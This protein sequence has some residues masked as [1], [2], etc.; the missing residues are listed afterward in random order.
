MIQELQ[1]KEREKA[2]LKSKVE[3]YSRHKEL[4]E[5]R[6]NVLI[7]LTADIEKNIATIDD[8][9]SAKSLREALELNLF[10]IEISELE[11]SFET[12]SN[13]YNTYLRD[14][15]SLVKHDEFITSECIKNYDTYVEILKSLKLRSLRSK[16]APNY[17]KSFDELIYE[18]DWEESTSRTNQEHKNIVFRR[19]VEI[20]EY[21]DKMK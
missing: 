10:Q 1:R 9:A 8:K 15:E 19:I 20:V 4:L 18:V 13:Y 6:I 21:M 11:A 7:L 5:K 17:Q 16:L 2:S 12:S 14:Y 3:Y